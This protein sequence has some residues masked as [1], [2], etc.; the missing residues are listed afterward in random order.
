MSSLP[1]SQD[2]IS[3]DVEVLSL[4]EVAA[5]LGVSTNRVRTLV[6]DHKLLA[7]SRNGQPGV[8]ALFFDDLGI[9]KHFTGLVEVLMDGGFSRDEA[10]RWLFTVQ[11]DLALHPAEALHTDFAREV[12]RRAQAEA[13]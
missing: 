7:V 12:I 10:M 11:D 8:P 9:A 6:R 13:F 2:V 1:L 3:A 5:R 4:E